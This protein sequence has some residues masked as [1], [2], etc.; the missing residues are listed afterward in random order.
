[1]EREMITEKQMKKIEN[2]HNLS[3][4]RGNLGY[5]IE[6]VEAYK[7]ISVSRFNRKDAEKL[8]K[9]YKAFIRR[10]ALNRILT[11][12]KTLLKVI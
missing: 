1:L 9:K 6:E 7:A 4:I 2:L 10:K 11:G 5:F 3:G 12:F 8:I